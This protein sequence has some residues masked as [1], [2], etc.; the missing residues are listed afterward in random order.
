MRSRNAADDVD[1]SVPLHRKKATEM[2]SS[3]FGVGGLFTCAI[4]STSIGMHI[5]GIWIFHICSNSEL[6]P[7]IRSYH[8]ALQNSPQNHSPFCPIATADKNTP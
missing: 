6:S 1:I 8:L 2:A 4:V 5:K 3:I 7:Q